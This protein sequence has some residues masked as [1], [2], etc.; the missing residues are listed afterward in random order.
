MTNILNLFDYPSLIDTGIF[1]VYGIAI[2][3]ELFI[4]HHYNKVTIYLKV[5]NK[6]KKLTF[7]TSIKRPINIM[8]IVKTKTFIDIKD[9][10]LQLKFLGYEHCLSC[11][12]YDNIY[13]AISST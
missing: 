4:F 9:L 1:I 3:K 6:T 11:N 2:D 13:L 7:S 5:N 8:R 10:Q 12:E